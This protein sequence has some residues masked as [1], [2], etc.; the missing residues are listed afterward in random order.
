MHLGVAQLLG[1]HC[2]AVMHEQET[3]PRLRFTIS[4]SHWSPRARGRTRPVVLPLVAPLPRV[5]CTPPLEE[6]SGRVC[7]VSVVPNFFGVGFDV[8][9]GFS[10]NVVSVVLGRCQKSWL[11]NIKSQQALT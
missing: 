8:V 1:V 4:C 5:V 11:F 2:N 3:S 9:D 7:R 6:V 10:T